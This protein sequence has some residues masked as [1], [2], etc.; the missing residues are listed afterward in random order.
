MNRSNR[1]F[2]GEQAGFGGNCIQIEE[3]TMLW[4]QHYEVKTFTLLHAITVI[5][6]GIK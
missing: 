3:I 2:C 6:I 5:H 4:L 1:H